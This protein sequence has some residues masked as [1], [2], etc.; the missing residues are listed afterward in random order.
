MRRGRA[1]GRKNRVSG[2]K[3]LAV[4]EELGREGGG[5]NLCVRNGGEG[6]PVCTS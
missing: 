3:N 4:G 1:E 5:L 6:K 2:E